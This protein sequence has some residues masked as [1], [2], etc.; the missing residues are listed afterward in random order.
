VGN[1]IGRNL[2]YLGNLR[3]RLAP[4]VAFGPEIMQIRT[5]YLQSGILRINR[6]DLA[7]G[8]FF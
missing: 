8:Y 2:T 3:F 4:N 7:L 5:T 1:G 6:Y